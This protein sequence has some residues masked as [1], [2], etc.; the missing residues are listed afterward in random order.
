[1]KIRVFIIPHLIILYISHITEC[2]IAVHDRTFQLAEVIYGGRV[3]PA[4]TRSDSGSGKAQIVLKNTIY[5][6]DFVETHNILV[7]YQ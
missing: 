5:V 4:N 2:E 3:I 7:Y 1:M 6:I